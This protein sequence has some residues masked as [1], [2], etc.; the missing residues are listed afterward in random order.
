MFSL[1]ATTPEIGIVATFL[2]IE[3]HAVFHMY[4]IRKSLFGIATAYGLDGSGFKS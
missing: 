1:S 2:H 3:L 4:G